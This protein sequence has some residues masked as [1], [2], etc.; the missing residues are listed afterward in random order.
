MISGEELR[1][2]TIRASLPN[3]NMDG[4]AFYTIT[5][6]QRLSFITE[7]LITGSLITRST[8]NTLT[9]SVSPTGNNTSAAVVQGLFANIVDTIEYRVND[10]GVNPVVSGTN[11]LTVDSVRL[12]TAINLENNKDFLA[13]EAVSYIQQSYPEYNFN[14]DLCKRDVKEFIKA[15]QYDLRYPG[16]YKTLLAARYY[17][18]A[19]TGSALDD[20][21][22]FRDTTG[23]KNA[24][25][26][27][28]EG[29]LPAA[30]EGE[31]YQLPTGGAF[32][33]L[34]PGWGPADSR[35][36]I[37]T[38][39]PYVQNVTTFGTG[40]IGQTVDG[41]LHNGG[42][43]SIVSNDFTQVISDGIGA[44]MLNG[45][46]GELVSVF[47]YYAHIGMFATNGGIIRATNGNSSYGDFGSIAD[48]ID[49]TETV[50]Y[51][52]LNTRTTQ[53][54]VASAFAGEINDF[55]FGL[56][57]SHAG[58][59]YTTASYS[60]VSSGTGAVAVQE[61]F[62]DNA[63]FV[64]YVTTPGQAYGQFGNQAQAGHT[65]QITLASA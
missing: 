48:G 5:A 57:F 27:G 20:M 56:E 65:T 63:L 58:Q 3:P 40:A 4:D 14:S 21:F 36:W 54:T 9:Q 33:S 7:N 8:G 11:T 26:R 51:G 22:Y 60:L 18:N 29:T 24:T 49:S 23:I 59:E 6:I 16:N 44:W 53:A 35:T 38:R 55:I 1:S 64:C 28:L 43:K 41:A 13:Q 25:L 61:E 34:D 37:T 47:S 31:D 19:V 30:V 52:K 45:G 46:R 42:N 17:S 39:S 10:E 50:R 12:Q 62:R 15:I 2:T 32:C